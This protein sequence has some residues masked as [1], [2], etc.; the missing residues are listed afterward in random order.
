M[1]KDV[2]LKYGFYIYYKIKNQMSNPKL[3][4]IEEYLLNQ[5]NI[6]KHY[7]MKFPKKIKQ[8]NNYAVIVEPRSNHK[9]LEAVCRNITYFLPEDWNLIVYSF[10]SNTLE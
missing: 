10:D 6:I 2:N 7:Q 9:L 1:K 8:T 3:N 5:S 4:L